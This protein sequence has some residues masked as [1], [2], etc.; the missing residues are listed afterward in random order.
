MPLK[1]RRTSDEVICID[2]TTESEDD[3]EVPQEIVSKKSKP[4]GQSAAGPL[5]LAEGTQKPRDETNVG[6]GS[7]PLFDVDGLE[8]VE[9]DA[10]GTAQGTTTAPIHP[11][12]VADDDPMR[13]RCR[14]C[15]HSSKRGKGTEA[16]YCSNCG[17]VASEVYFDRTPKA[18]KYKRDASHVLLGTRTI[19]FEIATRDPRAISKYARYWMGAD[20]AKKE[21]EYSQE[22]MDFD[23]FRHKLCKRP[24]LSTVRNLLAEGRGN[25]NKDTV[26]IRSETEECI[27]R[28][29]ECFSHFQIE[30]S[31]NKSNRSGVSICLALHLS[32]NAVV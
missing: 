26:R 32:S 7:F 14:K 11:N 19:S 5:H 22:E 31:W 9:L 10:E 1:R 15:H 13:I 29:L 3:Q 12:S 21:R 25:E 30:A 28:G 6:T 23:A 17:R 27:L 2:L 16:D 4:L 20:S 18:K 8:I 24:T